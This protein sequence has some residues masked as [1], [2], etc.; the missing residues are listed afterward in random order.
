MSTLTGRTNGP[1]HRDSLCHSCEA[2]VKIGEPR[3]RP[4]WAQR[5]RLTAEQ[6]DLLLVAAAE[7]AEL[8]DEAGEYELA[9]EFVDWIRPDVVGAAA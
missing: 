8:S 7:Y 3:A 5:L 6:H 2:R 9:V 1:A 4:L